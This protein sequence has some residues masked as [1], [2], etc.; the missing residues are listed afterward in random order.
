MTRHYVHRKAFAFLII[1]LLFLASG[2]FVQAGQELA[3]KA[4]RSQFESG[5]VPVSWGAV[6][7]SP[8]VVHVTARDGQFYVSP[9]SG[10]AYAVEKDL[11]R[12]TTRYCRTDGEVCFDEIVDLLNAESLDLPGWAT[13]VDPLLRGRILAGSNRQESPERVPVIIELEERAFTA[14]AVSA[15]QAVS[16]QLD[17]LSRAIAAP[18]AF[19]NGGTPLPHGREAEEIRRGEDNLVSL[20][21]DRVYLEEM[22]RLLDMTRRGIYAGAR[23]EIAAQAMGLQRALESLGGEV[24]VGT[25]VLSAV[26][27][28]VPMDSLPAIASL[29]S[30]RW[31]AEDRLMR[32]QLDVSA[33]TIRADTWWNSWYTGGVWDLAVVDTGIDG[34]HP[35]LTVDM[36]G[37]FHATAQGN[38]CYN[39]SPTNPDDFH[40]HGTHIAGIVAST[41]A[42]Y[43]G[44]AYGMDY[45]IN[46]KAG[47]AC[48]DGSSYMYWSDGMD[49]IDGAIQT[50]G[51]DVVS[52]S[53][54]GGP[55]SG[56]TA[57]GRFLDAVVDELGV[58]V[59]VSAGN[60]G[61]NSNTVTEPATAYN[62]LSVGNMNDQNTLARGDDAIRSSSSRG[63]TGDGRLKPDI[64]APG[65]SITSTN[66]DWEVFLQPDFVAMS[67]TSMAAPHVAAA[68]LLL[69]DGRGVNAPLAFKALLLNTADDWGIVGPDYTYGWGYIDLYEAH[70]NRN[71]VHEGLI[72]DGPVDYAFYRGPI[73]AGEKATLVWKRH[74]DY[75]GS[76]YPTTYY[77]LSDLDLYAFNETDNSLVDSSTSASENVEQVIAGANYPAIVYKVVP[78]GSFVGVTQ[79]PFALAG[80]EN[81]LPVS[82]P[83]LEVNLSVPAGAELGAD[84]SITA[85]V[86]NSGGLTA[87]A[88]EVTLNVPS[89]ATL[90]SGAN[91]QSLGVLTPGSQAVASWVARGVNP[92]TVALSASS[93]S[94]SYAETFANSSAEHSITVVDTTPPVSSVNDLSPITEASAF[95][96]TGDVMDWN[97]MDTVELFYRRNNGSWVSYGTDTT[98][99]WSWFF[100]SSITGGD[101][102][103]EFYTVATD[104]ATNV[105]LPPSTPDASTTVDTGPPTSWVTALSMYENATFTVYAN[106]EDPGTGV[107]GV[108]LL[109][110]KDG[111][112]WTSLGIDGTKPWSWE[113]NTSL[114]GGDGYY[115]FRS[116]S[117]DWLF[118]IENET[119]VNVPTTVDTA[120]PVSS[121]TVEGDLG[122]KGWYISS[123]NVTLT[124][125]D[126]TSGARTTHYR[127]DG[128]PWQLYNG[129]LVVT[130]D[131]IHTVEFYSI[132]EASNQEATRTLE[133]KV[134]STPPIL[135][136]VS[137]EAGG[138]ETSS[139]ALILWT[140]ED[141]ASGIDRYQVAVDGGVAANLGDR[142]WVSRELEDGSHSILVRAL[143]NAGNVVEA[144]VEFNL[145]STP[146]VVAITSPS[147]GEHLHQSIVTF[148]WTAEDAIS[149]VAGCSVSV[150]GGSAIPVGSNASW[151]S[152][153]LA[154][155]V[156]RT[157]VACIDGAGNTAQAMVLYSVDTNLVSPRGPVGP[158]LLIGLLALVAVGA[159]AVPY[160]IRRFRKVG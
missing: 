6:N 135:T 75:V 81:V 92:G 16:P 139:P 50:A 126:E 35:S 108:E 15:W 100:N 117:F 97:A 114:T 4:S 38:S 150:D 66:N 91:P 158:W 132:D 144:S 28:T 90:I 151:A 76:T 29:D 88:I 23:Q 39:D 17:E 128:G 115:E 52:L 136:I 123:V 79:E 104:A 32:M 64:V 142:S 26:Y 56:D 149:G 55:G 110:R 12:G 99:P 98:E 86:V 156:H 57:M 155:G 145:D 137:P 96:V 11:I 54:G 36:A 19:P 102:S 59:A 157:T 141:Q 24:R 89:G 40:G 134:D 84:F 53:F 58:M 33:Q 82:P 143:D 77:S 138:W 78:F 131:G 129:F 113:F 5:P 31:I 133:I 87:H 140:A 1:P 51:A 47:W 42:T 10:H 27:A 101:G 112:P 83:A 61:P 18:D 118:N 103:Y 152:P 147:E 34:T 69:M 154:D 127:V 130:E 153:T 125:V 9:L 146:P 122:S 3:P 74:V 37:V 2:I 119:G 107:A 120:P 30:V 70:F 63:P 60:A 62:I 49:A 111:G 72:G 21:E 43:T 105:E 7:G 106:A 67:G 93:F 116:V 44:V 25:P 94:N 48:T 65:T 80:E 22:D 148:R 13:K 109:Y 68:L 124:A 45:L 160:L 159:A 20:R 71:D 85:T 121:G 14:L 73:F 95:G 41:D 8:Q 46:A